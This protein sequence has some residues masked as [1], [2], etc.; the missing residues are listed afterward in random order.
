[1]VACTLAWDATSTFNNSNNNSSS[2]YSTLEDASSAAIAALQSTQPPSP[3]HAPAPRLTQLSMQHLPSE[4]EWSARLDAVHAELVPATPS[5]PKVTDVTFGTT[6]DF[7][8]GTSS[9]NDGI[10]DNGTSTAAHPL[11]KLSPDVALE[12]YLRNG[13]Q[14]LDELLAA[15]DSGF[16]AT[17]S[18]SGS[19]SD[20]SE[21]DNTS[22]SSSNGNGNGASETKS[23]R[24]GSHEN[25]TNGSGKSKKKSKSGMSKIV[26]AR[27]TDLQLEGHLDPLTL[28]EA[29]QERDPR[30]YQVFLQLSSGTTFLAS[31]PECLYTRSG[32]DVA[33]EAVAGTRARG[34]GGDIEKDFW[35]AFDL[36]RSEKDDVEFGVVR[37]WVRRALGT[38]CD[39]VRVEITKS[40]LKQGSVQHLYGKLAGKLKSNAGG[41][42]ALLAA[43]HPTPAVCGQ[44]RGDALN[45]LSE[46]ETFDRGLYSG[47]FGWISRDA[48]EFVVAIRSALIRPRAQSGGDN[49][50]DNNF[51]NGSSSASISSVPLSAYDVAL[52]AGVGIVCGS[53]TASEWAELNLK[54]SQFERLL[55]PA[56]ALSSS[57]NISALWARVMVEELC[58]LGCNTF[59][60]APGS[61][62]S[63][64][65]VAIASHPRAKIVPCIDER[66]LGFWALGYGRARGLPAV[67]VTS[68]GTAEASQ[69]H[70]PMLL[71]TADRPFE[72][73]ETGANQTI[74][75]VKIFGSYTRWDCDLEAPLE[76]TL[77]LNAVEKVGEAVRAACATPALPAG[78]VHLNCQFREPLA[79]KKEEFE[80]FKCLEG[81]YDWETSQKPLVT[82]L[83]IQHN[84][85]ARNGGAKSDSAALSVNS[86]DLA[87]LL[88]TARKAQ[89]GLLVIGELIQPEDVAAIV[90]LSQLL[91]WPIAADVLSGI[92]V[93]A[94]QQPHGAAVHLI[95][96]FDHLLLDCTHWKALKPD[97]VLQ[98]GGHLTSKRVAQFLDWC[99]GSSGNPGSKNQSAT[100]W[101][102]VSRSPLR[103][104]QGPNVSL[105]VKAT[106]PELL[107][108][109]QRRQQEEFVPQQ[110]PSATATAQ[111]TY[112][113]LLQT[114]DTEACV[115][116]DGALS[117]FVEL[118]EPA[119]A[120]VL[121]QELPPGEGLFIGN[122]M[123]IRDLDMYGMPAV[124][125]MHVD[126]VE[127]N[128]NGSF[129][130]I[131]TQWSPQGVVQA[132]VGAPVA[133]N[134]GASGIDGV[135]STAAGFADGLQRGTTLVVGDI[136]F[137]HDVNGLNLL[138]SGK[139]IHNFIIFF[140]GLL[141]LVSFFSLLAT[142]NTL[143]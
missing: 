80:N 94:Q 29:L 116:I 39:D 121:S 41:D 17:V 140:T 130:N 46:V 67:V 96:H 139:F 56:P 141:S 101:L 9:I 98:V 70:V 104:D 99:C 134:R 51:S 59:C 113:Q 71:L 110:I 108:A 84:G 22:S 120:R 1:M 92:R 32:S 77:A 33:S 82:L 54:I 58:R 40:V 48:A 16:E 93:G 105:R 107:S 15:L 7:N 43:L 55:K 126:I 95:S 53:D 12:E 97:V 52:F 37:D 111:V 138:R 65:T 137:L 47:P 102:F 3:P 69:S 78:P 87:A 19:G 4:E 50:N 6:S 136:S 20:D 31:T 42:A 45:M 109:F 30:A 28:L 62:S 74:D 124:R 68:S 103:Q 117:E 49:T 38:V 131:S 10:D 13:Q 81:I 24:N 79:P 114:L 18:N 2:G 8:N 132:G 112:C 57:P 128:S 83:K 75:Q 23:T 27:R 125:E 66:S 63:P 135:L 72:L 86:D 61:R 35:L 34:S 60:V 64:L 119:V 118:T 100:S 127:N 26:L 76:S 115:A 85:A 142:A 36:L 122:S 89:R 5:S 73:R 88:S 44:P 123:P 14:G 21:S 143:Y 90:Q 25:G 91:G 106:V 11:Q 133:A 129:A